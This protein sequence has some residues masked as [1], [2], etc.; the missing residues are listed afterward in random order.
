MMGWKWKFEV[1]CYPLSVAV[2]QLEMQV[3]EV[4]FS[5]KTYSYFQV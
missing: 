2:I 1:N 3:K 4:C 5:L